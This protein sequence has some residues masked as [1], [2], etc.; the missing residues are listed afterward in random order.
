MFKEIQEQLHVSLASWSRPTFCD[1]RLKPPAAAGQRAD[2][3]GYAAS[4]KS[5][6][7]YRNNALPLFVA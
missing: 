6:L 1:A 4:V 3:C 2:E 7:F 5:V